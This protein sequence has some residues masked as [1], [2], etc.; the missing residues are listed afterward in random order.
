MTAFEPWTSSVE[1][2]RSTCWA[3]S[4][5]LKSY[6]L[7]TDVNNTDGDDEMGTQKYKIIYYT[8]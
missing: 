4:T 7:F 3:T 1:S 6:L 2:D 8:N 5:A